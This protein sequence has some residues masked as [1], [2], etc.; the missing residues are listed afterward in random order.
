M[1]VAN[2]AW[3]NRDRTRMTCGVRN[4]RAVLNAGGAHTVLTNNSLNPTRPRFLLNGSQTQ[5]A[6]IYCE[7]RIRARGLAQKGYHGG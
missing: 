2:G 6:L 7:A 1:Q 5:V 3:V 4:C